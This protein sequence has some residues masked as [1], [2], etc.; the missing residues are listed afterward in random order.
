MLLSRPNLVLCI[1]L[2]VI[3][4]PDQPQETDNSNYV[5]FNI[6]SNDWTDQ[7]K[8]GKSLKDMTQ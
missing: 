3:Y 2:D 5:S 6:H 7:S 4:N 1:V 8:T